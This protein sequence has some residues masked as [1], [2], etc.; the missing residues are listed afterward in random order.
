MLNFGF[1]IY[2]CLIFS[3]SVTKFL[4]IDTY[5]DKSR[6]YFKLQFEHTYFKRIFNFMLYYWETKIYFV[7]L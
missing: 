4:N 7:A 1:E 6:N 5:N 2:K 3:S